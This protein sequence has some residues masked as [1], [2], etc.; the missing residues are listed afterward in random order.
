MNIFK[1][2][3]L[4]VYSFKSYKEFLK[5]KKIKVFGFGL[6]LM[7][8]YFLI[9]YAV[10]F[11]VSQ[12]GPSNLTKLIEE[13]VPEF[14]LSDGTLWVDDVIEYEMNDQYIYIDT[15]PYYVFYGAEE[16]KQY[17]VDYRQ[18]FLLDS[19]KIIA[20]SNGEVVELYYEDLGW[21][22]SKEKLIGWVPYIYIFMAMLYAF[23][24]VWI[25]ALFFFG[26]LFVALFGMIIASCMKDKLTFGQLY[27]LGIYS[28]TLP[29]LIKA[30]LSLL[31]IRVPFTLS[32]I[33]NLGL[34]LLYLG[35]AMQKMKEQL[36]QQP[37][38]Y[39]SE[40]GNNNPTW[41]Q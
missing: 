28:R 3:V 38:Q 4:S 23:V 9:A 7:L 34:S 25:T 16:M 32:L 6:M 35:L 10:P 14:E 36:P 37:L 26:V 21:E 27:L 39:T 8:L 13:E 20:K 30:I 18:A 22:F 31:N 12:I 11:V 5:N 19:E 2:M 33:I 15:D 29:L 24:F 17:L 1:E 40:N 41:M